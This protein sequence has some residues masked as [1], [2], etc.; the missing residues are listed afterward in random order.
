MV[1]GPERIRYGAGPHQWAD[2]HRPR[3]ESRGVVVVIH[4]GFWKARYDATLGEPLAR[5]LAARGWTACNLEYRRVG[6][7]GGGS[8]HSSGTLSSDPGREWSAYTLP[9]ETKTKWSAMGPR[10]PTARR[11]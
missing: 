3:G 1:R 8:P 5:D 7:G 11:T 10:A 6:H 9:V 4:G 2:L